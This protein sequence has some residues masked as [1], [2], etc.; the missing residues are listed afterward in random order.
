[1]AQIAE[2]VQRTRRIPVELRTARPSHGGVYWGADFLGF[3]V[4]IFFAVI[5]L[6]A[7]AAVVGTVGYQMGTTFP[8]VGKALSGTQKHLAIA[9]LLGVLAALFLA[10]LIGGYAAGRMARFDGARNGLGV[11]R[12]TIIVAVILAI[13]TGILDLRFNFVSQVHTSLSAAT[14]TAAGVLALAVTLL[15]MSVSSV[16]GGMLGVRYH[17]HID[18]DSV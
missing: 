12:W 18:R 2:Q 6:G 5:F 4:A 14:L 17:H 8:D 3:T 11:V 16:I 15:V 10:Y 7:V 1:M 9:G 13:V